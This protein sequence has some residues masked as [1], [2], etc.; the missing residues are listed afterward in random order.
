MEATGNHCKPPVILTYAQKYISIHNDESKKT[1]EAFFCIIMSHL[2]NPLS[3]PVLSTLLS[4]NNG[5]II[6]VNHFLKLIIWLCYIC[7]YSSPLL[8]SSPSLSSCC[9]HTSSFQP[10]SITRCSS[11]LFIA[12]CRASGIHIFCSVH[13]ADSRSSTAVF[14]YDCVQ[15]L[16]SVWLSRRGGEGFLS[17]VCRKVGVTWLTIKYIYVLY[18]CCIFKLICLLKISL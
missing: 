14:L 1:F 18:E 11:S 7:I 5:C 15:F 6:P 4:I 10:S 8:C 13:L 3:F 12:T 2:H 17:F 9:Y 16:P